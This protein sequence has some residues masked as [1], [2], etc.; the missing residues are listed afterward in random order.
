VI[1]FRLLPRTL[2]LLGVTAALLTALG[3]VWGPVI[4]HF[5]IWTPTMRAADVAK[6]RQAPD[7][8]LLRTIAAQELVLE[9][10]SS[11]RDPVKT[12]AQVLEG[13]FPWGGEAFRVT[14]P[15]DP[16]DLEQG[17]GAHQLFFAGLIVPEILLRAYESTRDE[18]YFIAARQM[19]LAFSRFERGKILHRGLVWNDHAVAARVSVLA[20]FWLNYRSRPDFDQGEARAILEQVARTAEMLATA[21]HFTF[22]SNHGVMQNVGL[23]QAGLAFPQLER[24]ADYRRIALERLEE[25]FRFYVNTEGAVLEHSAG[26]HFHGVWLTGLLF[27]LMQAGSLPIPEAWRAQHAHGLAYLQALRRPD[28]TLPMYGDTL[29][30][31][32]ELRGEPPAAP[33]AVALA[34]GKTAPDGALLPIAGY[35]V[36]WDDLLLDEPPRSVQAQIAVPW[37]N[38]PGH[39]HKHADEMSLHLWAD[40]VTWLTS[41]GYWP[42]AAWQRKSSHGW[43]GASAP[44]V[45][46]EP[47]KSAR[48]TVLRAHASGSGVRM[49]DLERTVTGGPTLRRQLV[50]VPPATWL[51]LDRYEDGQRRPLRVLWQSFPGAALQSDGA[52]HAYRLTRPD[53]MSALHVSVRGSAHL[54]TRVLNGSRDPYGGWVAIGWEAAPAHAIEARLADPGGWL[55]TALQLRPAPRGEHGLDSPIVR[56]EVSGPDRWR[57]LLAGVDEPI[58]IA[59]DVTGLSLERASSGPPQPIAVTPGMDVTAARADLQRAFLAAQAKYPRYRDIDFYRW[60]VTWLLAGSWIALQALAVLTLRIHPTPAL[61]RGAI[62]LQLLWLLAAIAGVLFYLR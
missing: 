39:A 38:F 32:K 44:H 35:A 18:R 14:L 54:T 8:A 50:Y 46:D 22:H 20:R 33:D 36:W 57:V 51:V 4:L 21:R 2:R 28:L 60:R 37:S 41:A 23:L 30:N 47:E 27:E 52:N 40:G 48:T 19:L 43:S 13:R 42:D 49:L 62:A 6:H 53:S 29:D 58:T 31:P 26:Y 34:A 15:F 11:L 45:L 17:S 25:Q 59:R 3:F 56:A 9:G 1:V 61:R 5:W 16:A 7:D 24:A 55:L 12:A 10:V